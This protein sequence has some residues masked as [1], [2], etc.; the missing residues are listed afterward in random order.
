MLRRGDCEAIW[1]FRFWILDSRLP[2]ILE[3]SRTDEVATQILSAECNKTRTKKSPCLLLPFFLT[4]S[5]ALT[6]LYSLNPP[7]YFKTE[8]IRCRKLGNLQIMFNLRGNLS[9]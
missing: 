6:A 9:R 8:V 1:D 4:P 3:Y 5:T 2:L 7:I